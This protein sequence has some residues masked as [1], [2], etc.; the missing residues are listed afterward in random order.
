MT[1]R[2]VETL[3]HE[4]GH[5]LQ[6]MLTR[7]DD[8]G[9]SGLNLIEWDAVEVASQFMENWCVD[10]ATLSRF[11]FHAETHEPIPAALVEKVRAARNYRAGEACLRQLSFAKTDMLLHSASFSGDPDDV[12]KRVFAD[13]D[14]PMIPEDRFL[15]A[16]THIFAGGYA[17]GYYGYKWSEVMSADVFGAFEDAGLADEE[18][19]R[20]T[21]RRYRDTFLAL[22]GSLDPMEVFRRFRGRGPTIDAMLRQQGLR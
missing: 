11:A 20:R 6:H 17:A 19:V 18:A 10:T 21:G 3:F 1:F 5:A 15:C 8:E 22:G 7:V 13:Y 4:F 9:A 2:E 12:K 14:M 16:F